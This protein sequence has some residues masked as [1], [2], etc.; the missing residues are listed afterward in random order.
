MPAGKPGCYIGLERFDESNSFVNF[1]DSRKLS[2][3]VFAN[4]PIAQGV[5]CIKAMLSQ[6]NGLGSTFEY[7]CVMAFV[8]RSAPALGAGYCQASQQNGVPCGVHAGA[9]RNNRL[10]RVLQF[11]LG[12]L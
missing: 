5:K 4:A 6:S 12:C 2:G 9:W 8:A 1:G 11:Q 10:L 7:C 3:P